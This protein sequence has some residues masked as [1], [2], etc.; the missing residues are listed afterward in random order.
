[1]IGTL[2]YINLDKVLKKVYKEYEQ[3]TIEEFTKEGTCYG[4][5]RPHNQECQRRGCET[6]LQHL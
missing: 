6:A 1:M 5:S 2:Q 3:E 4:T